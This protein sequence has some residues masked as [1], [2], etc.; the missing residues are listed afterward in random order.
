MYLYTK[1]GNSNSKGQN[2]TMVSQL[3]SIQG[4]QFNQNRLTLIQPNQ[5]EI[6]GE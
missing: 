1:E 4:G 6:Q 5:F 3:E 2:Q